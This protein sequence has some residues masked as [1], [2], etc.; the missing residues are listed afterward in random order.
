MAVAVID[1]ATVPPGRFAFIDADTGTPFEIGSITKALTGMLLADAVERGEISLD[2]LVGDLVPAASTDPF[3]SITVRELCTHTSGLPRLARHPLAFLRTLRFGLLQLDPYRGSS[4]ADVLSLAARQTLV[5]RGRHRYSNL[6]G[7]VLGQLLAIAC[8]SPYPSLLADRILHPLGMTSSAVA[9]RGAAAPH[10]WSPSGLP[11]QPW[12]MDG[13]APAGGVVSTIGD[14]ARLAGALLDGSAPG[15]ASLNPIETVPTESPHRAR[16]MFWVV[17]SVPGTGRSVVGHLGRT[18]GYSALFA[19]LPRT[20]RAV[21][22]LENVSRGPQERQRLA[23]GLV[24]PTFGD[25]EF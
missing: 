3:G 4:P 14:M 7:A 12:V 6:G 20:R 9:T 18:G 15:L 1:M 10:G 2:T 23:F 25:P 17:D 13:Y 8:S 16:G 5:D 24:A 11:R 19:L 22:I 21:V